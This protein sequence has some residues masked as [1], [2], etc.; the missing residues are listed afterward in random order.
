MTP[1]PHTN[2]LAKEMPS[3]EVPNEVIDLTT[4]EDEHEKLRSKS[5][6]QRSIS[7]PVVASDDKKSSFEITATPTTIDNTFPFESAHAAMFVSSSSKDKTENENADSQFRDNYVTRN[8]QKL[9]SITSKEEVSFEH[10]VLLKLSVERGFQTS[11]PSAITCENQIISLSSNDDKSQAPKGSRKRKSKESTS[12]SHQ[13]QSSSSEDEKPPKKTSKLISSKTIPDIDGDLFSSLFVQEVEETSKNITKFNSNGEPTLPLTANFQDPPVFTKEFKDGAW[14]HTVLPSLSAKTKLK[15]RK[16]RAQMVPTL[17][18]KNHLL[19]Q[20]QWN[21]I[22]WTNMDDGACHYVVTKY[23]TVGHAKLITPIEAQ[24][25]GFLSRLFDLQQL[26]M[27]KEVQ[28]ALAKSKNKKPNTWTIGFSV[29]PGHQDGG[30]QI[31]PA[32]K[33]G[34][35]IITKVLSDS[36]VLAHE[37]L[38][39]GFKETTSEVYDSYWIGEASIALGSEFNQSVTSLQINISEPAQNLGDENALGSAGKLHVDKADNEGGFS[40]VFFLSHLPEDYFPGRFVLPGPKIAC[41]TAPGSTLIFKGSCLHFGVTPRPYPKDLPLDSLLRYRRPKDI[42]YPKLPDGTPYRRIVLVNY[43]TRTLTSP[44]FS[45][46]RDEVFTSD[47]LCVFG[48]KANFQEWKMKFAIRNAPYLN[49]DPDHWLERYSWEIAGERNYPRR[50]I[51]VKAIQIVVDKSSH[52]AA[53]N[54]II[55]ANQ[56][57]SCGK[58]WVS[59]DEQDESKRHT[60]RHGEVNW[61][62]GNYIPVFDEV[63]DTVVGNMQ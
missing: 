62:Q 36:A 39:Y 28:L 31:G 24:N 13:K 63:T 10:N 17:V 33:N 58:I 61:T 21:D 3:E 42:V 48:T 6:I 20:K 26:V 47:A 9:T 56:S 11:N 52:K 51:A 38:V 7:T 16:E 60:H 5:S 14:Y 19:T 54:N 15:D 55:L 46:L 18:A 44:I 50:S 27:S 37:M 23:G 49:S 34:G 53:W 1:N 29:Q 41:T 12:F 4:N 40:I 22:G 30:I 2:R 59:Q 45:K 25:H 8:S 32:S 35:S 43:P 57:I